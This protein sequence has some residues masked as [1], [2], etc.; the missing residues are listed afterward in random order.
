MVVR[1]LLSFVS[2]SSSTQ[3]GRPQPAKKT[4]VVQS[5][6]GVDS[7][8]VKMVFALVK[9]CILLCGGIK[10]FERKNLMA[11]KKEQ[12]KPSK[13]APKLSAKELMGTRRLRRR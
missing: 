13:K 2:R 10:Y 1:V 8:R 4:A 12:K 6:I 7:A 5:W 11:L 3:H 9:F